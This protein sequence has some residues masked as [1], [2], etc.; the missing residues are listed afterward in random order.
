[1]LCVDY[2]LNYIYELFDASDVL[3]VVDII[4]P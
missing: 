4:P 1:M 2:I 3:S